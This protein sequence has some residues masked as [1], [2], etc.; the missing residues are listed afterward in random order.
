MFFV[1]RGQLEVVNEDGSIVYAVI[2]R[3]ENLYQEQ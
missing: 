2:E 3:G 1:G